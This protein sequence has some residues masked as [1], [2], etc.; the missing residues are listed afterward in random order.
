M[1]SSFNRAGVGIG[2]IDTA[3]GTGGN[4]QPVPPPLTLYMINGWQIN[5]WGIN[6]H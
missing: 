6:Q 5:G 4:W 3:P 1:P 2:R